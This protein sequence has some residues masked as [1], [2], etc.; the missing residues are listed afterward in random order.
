MKRL[1]DERITSREEADNVFRRI[2]QLTVAIASR[3]YRAK[4]RILAIEQELAND[5]AAERADLATQEEALATYITANKG[6]FQDPRKVKLPEGAYGLQEVAEVRVEDEMKAGRAL[7]R[8]R[9]N[10][11]YERKFV[12]F[13]PALKKR[14]LAGDKIPGVTLVTGDTVVCSVAPA[15]I[16]KAEQADEATA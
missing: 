9:L 2:A 14:L 15:I 6:Q 4:K 8:L 11:C 12:I 16:K 10:E 13:K 5:T 7:I 3:T 1:A